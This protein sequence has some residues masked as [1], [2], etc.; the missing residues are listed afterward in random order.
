M[1]IGGKTICANTKGVLGAVFFFLGCLFISFL[2]LY[3]D[4]YCVLL[5]LEIAMKMFDVIAMS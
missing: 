4:Q 3:L 1:T 2:P 5:Q